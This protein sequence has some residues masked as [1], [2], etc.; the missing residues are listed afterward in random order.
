MINVVAVAHV[1]EECV[2]EYKKLASE[3]VG[4]KKGSRLFGL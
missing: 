4:D 2:E 3:L 1:K